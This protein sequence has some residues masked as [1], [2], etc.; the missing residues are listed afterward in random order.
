MKRIILVI[1]A[2]VMCLGMC[3]CGGGSEAEESE[4][5]RDKVISSVKSHIMAQIALGYDTVG[6]P[7]IT[8]YVEEVE[9]NVYEVTGKITV[10]DKYGDSYTGKYDSTVEYDPELGSCD[11][12]LDIDKLYK[13]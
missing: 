8:T 12:D 6:V 7:T 2:V 3:A 5:P 10:K 13:D 9:E 1:L 4:T 11:V